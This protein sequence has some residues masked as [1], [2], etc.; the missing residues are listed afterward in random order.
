MHRPPEPLRRD[1]RARR[2][3]VNGSRPALAFTEQPHDH[4]SQTNLHG[5]RLEQKTCRRG[6]VRFRRVR[7]RHLLLKQQ[8]FRALPREKQMPRPPGT[9]T[10]PAL[11][12]VGR[13]AP[14][15]RGE[16]PLVRAVPHERHA[17]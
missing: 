1:P 4:A 2:T 3:L 16:P 10:R 13:P 8:G 5:T 15:I 6:I 17:E 7:R 12:P 11:L 14:K 9:R